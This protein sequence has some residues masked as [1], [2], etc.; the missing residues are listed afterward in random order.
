MLNQLAKAMEPESEKLL[1]ERSKCC[2]DNER[3]KF[4]SKDVNNISIPLIR[5]INHNN[6]SK[7][8]KII[9]GI[10][11][12]IMNKN[13]N[14]IIIIILG[15]NATAREVETSEAMEGAFEAVAESPQR[16]S[17]YIISR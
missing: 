3:P 4:L 16:L 9:K 12:K 14:N 8:I 2:N 7:I 10:K 13:N 5:P 6:K 17:A 1:S 11:V 15:T